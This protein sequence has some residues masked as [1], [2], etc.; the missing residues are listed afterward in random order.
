MQTAR[1]D[2]WVLLSME[3]R[4][5]RSQEVKPWAEAWRLGVKG[6]KKISNW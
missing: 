5:C 6:K 2:T 1:K 4:R 3:S